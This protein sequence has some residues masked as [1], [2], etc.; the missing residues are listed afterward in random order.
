MSDALAFTPLQ[1]DIKLEHPD[2][3]EIRDFTSLVIRIR[4]THDIGINVEFS[5]YLLYQKA[6]ESYSLDTVNELYEHAGPPPFHWLYE[7]TNSE[8]LTRFCERNSHLNSRWVP[9]HYL[10]C[11]DNDVVDVIALNAPTVSARSDSVR[12]WIR[13]GEER[14]G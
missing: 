2:I 10:V 6:D 3:D 12:G 1:T 14:S 4:D 5:G 13:P 8:F 7:V 9:R 11:T